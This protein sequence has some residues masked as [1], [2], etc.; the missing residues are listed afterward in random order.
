MVA[1]HRIRRLRCRV[2]AS[3][4]AD[5]FALRGELRHALDGIVIPA[6]ASAFDSVLPGDDLV[7][8]ARLEVRVSLAVGSDLSLALPGL[9]AAVRAQ[10]EAALDGERGGSAPVV[11]ARRSSPARSR[12]QALLVYLRRG[13]L[14]SAHTGLPADDTL[15][16]LR[17]AVPELLPDVAVEWRRAGAF[18][19]FLERLLQLMPETEWPAVGGGFDAGLP[20]A[21]RPRTAE[22]IER[23][24]RSQE[25]VG[26]N[27]RL[28]AA[29]NIIVTSA[30]RSATSG[31]AS[32]E[33]P[34]AGSAPAADKPSRP[35]DRNRRSLR[36]RSR[37]SVDS[38]L[39]LEPP[40]SRQGA[41]R[42]AEACE[43]AARDDLPIIVPHAG[44]V[45]L[46]PFL[47]RLFEV[48]GI[49]GPERSAL[50]A[51]TLHRAASLLYWL[52]TGRGEPVEF[53]LGSIKLLL[54]LAPSTPLVVGDGLLTAGEQE[55]AD[56]L[57]AAAIG[58]WTVLKQTSVASFRAGFL[59]RTG[60][61]YEEPDGWRLRVQPESFDV[62]LGQLPWAIGVVKL[63]WMPR[64]VFCEWPAP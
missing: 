46:H 37:P 5:G 3:P 1:P 39:D 12:R 60:L 55:E 15:S 26:R 10:L 4:G 22:A 62:L 56:A 28:Q 38:L 57:V 43:G 2:T 49:A 64:P 24:I 32:A 54:G 20:P 11:G 18:T 53:E 44:L 59:Q 21:E 23:L 63:P 50:A 16:L 6:L 42:A 34:P 9:V 29:V 61:L 45:L 33:R 17:A 58:H 31:A 52:A 13:V 41:A 48:T 25:Y 40:T 8:I 27:A 35:A 30:T 14:P 47:P 36:E 7:E 51:E 19:E